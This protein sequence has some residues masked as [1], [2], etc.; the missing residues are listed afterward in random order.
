MVRAYDRYRCRYENTERGV[1]Y[2]GGG[3]ERSYGVI[4][5]DPSWPSRCEWLVYP[6]AE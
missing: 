3:V 2:R 1:V 4:Y 6:E 5:G